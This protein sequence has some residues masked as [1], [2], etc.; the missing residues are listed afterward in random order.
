MS[1]DRKPTDGIKTK[2]PSL[3]E[4]AVEEI[5]LQDLEEVA[6]GGGITCVQSNGGD[7]PAGCGCQNTCPGTKLDAEFE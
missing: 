5:P 7:Q 1:D 4:N 3:D 6:G 2:L